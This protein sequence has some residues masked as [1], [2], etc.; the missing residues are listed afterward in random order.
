MRCKELAMDVEENFYKSNVREG[1]LMC[2][3]CKTEIKK[4]GGRI[5][6]HRKRENVSLKVVTNML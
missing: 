6:Q 1:S 3:N 5:W 4:K 2:I